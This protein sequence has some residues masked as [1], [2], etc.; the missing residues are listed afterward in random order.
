[1]AWLIF[2]ANLFVLYLFYVSIRSQRDDRRRTVE[3]GLARSWQ[4]HTGGSEVR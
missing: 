4:R 1:M 2:A 3:L